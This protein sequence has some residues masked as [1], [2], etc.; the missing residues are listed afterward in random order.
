MLWLGIQ[1]ALLKKGKYKRIQSHNLPNYRIKIIYGM[2]FGKIRKSTPGEETF[3]I[4]LF[5]CSPVEVKKSG[6]TH[7]YI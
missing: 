4:M 7:Q 6:I 3:K 1:E 2:Q 5:S